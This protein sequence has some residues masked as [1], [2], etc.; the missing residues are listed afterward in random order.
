[1]L[2]RGV[3]D[4]LLRVGLC[5]QEQAFDPYETLSQDILNKEFH[6]HFNSL[7]SRPTVGLYF[8]VV[9]RLHLPLPLLLLLCQDHT[10]LKAFTVKV[11]KSSKMVSV[12][13]IF[14]HFS[15]LFGEG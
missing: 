12:V 7:M 9:L 3:S 8:Q 4:V 15:N 5:E 13:W 14:Q 2:W 6:E 1:V 11:L 10:P